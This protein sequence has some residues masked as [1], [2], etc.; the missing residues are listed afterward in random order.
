MESAV[1][2]SADLYTDERRIYTDERRIYTDERRIYTDKGRIYTDE[3]LSQSPNE[4]P[5][6]LT[7]RGY[8]RER[9]PRTHSTGPGTATLL[10]ILRP[11]AVKVSTRAGDARGARERQAAE[12]GFAAR[13]TPPVCRLSHRIPNFTLT[14]H[15]SDRLRISFE[16][17]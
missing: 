2:E 13:R 12:G 7:P 4:T 16:F 8:N 14:Q 9:N 10:G 15:V 1:L 17:R 5:S 11:T 6:N 3:G